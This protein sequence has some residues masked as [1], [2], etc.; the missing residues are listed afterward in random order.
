MNKI[1]SKLRAILASLRGFWIRLVHRITYAINP[2]YKVCYQVL[3][4]EQA[5]EA[6]KEDMRRQEIG[7]DMYYS[8]YQYKQDQ[9]MLN[10]LQIGVLNLRIRAR[11]I[12]KKGE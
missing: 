12:K 3:Q 1:T 11:E 10:R 8:S 7:N 9:D 4:A 2:L 6:H 5:L